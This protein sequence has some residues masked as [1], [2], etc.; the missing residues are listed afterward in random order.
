MKKLTIKIVLAMLCLNFN[1]YAQQDK[2]V[3]TE[4]TGLQIGQKVPDVLLYNI[5]NYKTKTAKLSDFKGKLLILDFWATWCS[6]CVTMFPKMDSLQRK[7][8]GKLQFLSVTYQSAK[9]VLPF[10]VR[11]EELQKNKLTIPTIVQDKELNAM[12]PHLQLP[13]YVWITQDGIVKAIT[14]D[15]EVTEA[16]IAESL[17]GKAM[18]LAVKADVASKKTYDPMEPLLMNNNGGDGKNLLYHSIF[19]GYS[20]ELGGGGSVGPHINE[21]G[22][23]LCEFNSSIPWFY[24]RAY[25]DGSLKFFNNNVV[26]LKVKDL[27]KL[28]SEG[29]GAPV[30][31]WMQK[32]NVFSYELFVPT[33]MAS[34]FFEIMKGD[35]KRIFPQ[36]T[37]KIEIQ[38]VKCMALTRISKEDRIKTKNPESRSYMD[39]DLLGMKLINISLDAF[40]DRL[41]AYYFQGASMPAINETHY[42]GKVD[43]EIKGNPG[44]INNLNKSLLPYGL[45]FKEVKRKT[46]ILVIRDT[47]NK[48]VTNKQNSKQLGR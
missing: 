36:Y 48:P 43:L 42:K 21:K 7:F 26:Q 6:P 2:S 24:K 14:G 9:D 19:T 27:D 29:E 3:V 40:V 30:L 25:G 5:H 16:I 18:N 4:K 20:E 39:A 47:K 33:Y 17:S 28:E 35:L 45:K 11:F 13:H 34:Q 44:D 1:T 32:G 37:A 8:E 31:K 23:R 41:Q 22:M 15:K 38:K 10:L 46:E 12:F